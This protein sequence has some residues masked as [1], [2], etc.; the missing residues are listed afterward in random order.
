SAEA[1][2]AKGRLFGIYTC[3]LL[4]ENTP[5]FSTYSTDLLASPPRSMYQRAYDPGE[6]VPCY[7]CCKRGP[8]GELLLDGLARLIR[9]AG[10]DGIYS[11]GTSMAWECDNPSHRGCGRPEP[12]RWKGDEITRVVGQRRFLK[13]LRGIFDERGKPFY[14]AAHCGG[15]LD[16]N[17]LSFFDGFLEGEQL[18]RFR[19]GY[20][21]PLSTMAVGYCGHPWGFRTVFWDVFYSQVGALREGATSWAMTYALPHDVELNARPAEERRLFDGFEDER[22][23]TFYPY[24]RPQPHLKRLSGNVLCSYWRK[25]QEAMVV[26]S[27]LTWNDQRTLLD[28]SRLF[29]NRVLRVAEV[30][31]D[32]ALPQS[33]GRV[34]LTVKSHQFLAMRVS[35]LESPPPVVVAAP[36][37]AEVPAAPFH[38]AGLAAE[39][40]GFNAGDPGVTV[41]NDW[42]LGTG[43]RCFRLKSTIWQAEARAQFKAHLLGRDWTARLRIQRSGRMRFRFGRTGFFFD[44]AWKPASVD[45]WNEGRL[46]QPDVSP[47]RTQILI[48]SL[49]GC[50]LDAVYGGQPLARNLKL[51]GL[52]EANAFELATWG[53]DW[54]AFDVLEISSE[55]T[56]LYAPSVRHPVL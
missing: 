33:Q 10:I 7:L 34:D 50:M 54:F 29:P 36:S 28:L 18:A 17:T 30:L 38:V 53:G 22:E 13:R 24:W 40:W 31:T 45:L 39:Q 9:E 25:S 56:R 6:G 42:D 46:Y 47:E 20:R 3:Q 8:E 5:G 21:L 19:P 23:V 4:A 52:T 55:P 44:S 12:I 14:L 11:D 32:A 16:I 49:H 51:A 35:P 41:E 1:A 48:L 27:N 43:R 37:A 15:G 2:H 26:V